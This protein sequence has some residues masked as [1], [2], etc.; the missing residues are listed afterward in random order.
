MDAQRYE[1][2]K[3]LYM[4]AAELDATEAGAFLAAACAGDEPLRREVESLLAHHRAETLLVD[5]SRLVAT[6]QLVRPDLNGRLL[7]T[8]SV[9]AGTDRR[10]VAGQS[11][12]AEPERFPPGTIVAGRYRMLGL[13]GRGG[14]GEVYRADDLRLQQPVALKFLA[15]SRSADERWLARFHGEVRLAQHMQAAERG[16]VRVNTAPVSSVG[17]REWHAVGDF[18][19]VGHPCGSK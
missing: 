12:P 7:D 18:L 6:G 5:D 1:L 11:R 2:V 16:T 10:G 9:A 14:M 13:L 19:L 15:P 4:A 3:R 8:A 17:F